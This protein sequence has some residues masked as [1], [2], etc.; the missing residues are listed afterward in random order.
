[1]IRFAALTACCVL[2]LS[3]SVSAQDT[4]GRCPAPARGPAAGAAKPATQ[5]LSVAQLRDVAIKVLLE[6]AVGQDSTLRANALEA[7]KAE[8]ELAYPLCRRALNDPKAVVRF[9]AL[10]ISGTQTRKYPEFAKLSGRIYPLM[11]DRNESVRAAAF[12]ALKQMGEPVDISPLALMLMNGD[13]KLRGNVAMLLAL[14]GD[15]SAVQM[16]RRAAQIRKPREGGED[17]ALARIQIAEAAVKL[18]D[19]RSLD[20]LRGGMWSQYADARLQAIAAAGTVNDRQMSPHLL[21]LL[22]NPDIKVDPA[23]NDQFKAQAALHRKVLQLVAAQSLAKMK[24]V[25]G[26]E[27]AARYA[28]DPNPVV[29]KEAASCL[30][31]YSDEKSRKVLQKLL[32][33]PV[34]FVKV[35]AAASLVRRAR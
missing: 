3:L 32:S 28:S 17:S 27:Y 5:R 2:G 18:G 9:A 34:K 29:R 13:R 14:I 15:R 12:F 24:S 1:M 33:D 4:I 6:A 7:L 10:V 20:S 19:T 16:L 30:G 25:Q 23:A 22:R 31:W 35:A 11:K 8:R 21:N 26:L